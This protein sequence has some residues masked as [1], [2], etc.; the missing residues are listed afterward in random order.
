M[1]R[2]PAGYH[3]FWFWNDRISPAGIARQLAAMADQGIR[4]VYIHP[5]QGLAQPYLSEAF[6]ELVEVALD[7]AGERGMAVHLYDEYPYPSGA[8]GGAVVQSDPGLAG[9]R[10]EHRSWDTG[11]GPFRAELPAGR[12]VACLA[13]PRREGEVAWEHPIDLADHVGTVLSTESY[14]EGGLGVYNDRRYFADVPLPVLWATLPAG[15]HHVVAAVLVPI[16]DHKYWGAYPDVANPDAVK[17]WMELTHERYDARLGARLGEL[18]SL[19]VDEV[20]PWASTA[21]VEEMVRLNATTA[22]TLLVAVGEPTHPRHLEALSQMSRVRLECFER[23]FEQPVSSWCAGHG[24]PYA[25]EKPSLRLSQLRWMDIPG[26]EP[27]HIKAGAPPAVLLGDVL[28]ATIRGNARA[29]ASAAYLYGKEGALCECYHSLG[30]DATLQDAKL[31]AD[32]LVA[33]GIRWLVPHAF[34]YSVHGLRKHDAPPSFLQ[35]PY[36]PLFGSLS[37]HVE[38]IWRHLEGTFPDAAV[39]V[40]EPSWGLPDEE[41]R[42]CYEALQR[43]LVARQVEWLAVDTDV[44]ESSRV[45]S[46]VAATR[47]VAF[48]AVV[49]PPMRV[50]EPPLQ[51]W[52]S[53]FE[54]GGGRVFRLGGMAD[55]APVLDAL[56]TLCQSQLRICPRKGPRENVLCASR[57]RGAGAGQ[58]EEGL[59]FLVNVG[60]EPVEIGCSGPPDWDVLPLEGESAPRL[61]EIDGE[62][63]LRLERFESALLGERA[64]GAG[65]AGGEV[66]LDLSGQWDLRTCSPNVLRL[67]HWHMRLGPDLEE[68]AVTPAPLANQLRQARIPFAP[69]VTEQFGLSPRL[70]LA[71][72]LASYHATFDCEPEVLDTGG[73]LYLVVEPGSVAGDWRVWVNRAGPF[74]CTDLVDLDAHVQGCGGLPLDDILRAGANEVVVEVEAARLDHGLRNPLYVAGG[75][76]VEVRVARSGEP[77]GRLVAPLQQ[78]AIG[79]WAGAK[80]GYYA[81]AVEYARE[82]SH[83]LAGEVGSS[84]IVVRLELPEG[85]EEALEVAFGDGPWHPVPWSPRRFEVPAGELTGAPRVRVRAWSGLARAFEGRWWDASSNAYRIVG[86][87]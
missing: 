62:R 44:L 41:G 43:A 86:S 48:R 34:F 4:G 40:V 16:G 56:E 23:S 33:L 28:R 9:S 53:G 39:A 45:E 31:L 5:R 52:L 80:L 49:V 67:G 12:V 6:F 15:E 13:F 22:P 78:G 66:R 83:A 24:L 55:V 47:D 50:V 29:T 69:R 70:E 73:A 1:R 76:G 8:A 14:F 3:A 7:R 32:V 17:R 37:R 25:G 10:L 19:F 77:R 74:V 42:A 18:G 58:P 27:G 30:W 35:M 75:F 72:V 60:E 63:V 51:T 46:G 81:G 84:T 26:C 87:G 79:D 59:W 61:E 21:V 65:R 64:G 71:P 2:L 82:G 36:W 20:T 57:R 54:K 68:F 38:A 11:G 85:I